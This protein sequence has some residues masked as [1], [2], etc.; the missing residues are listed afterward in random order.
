MFGGQ[1]QAADLYP[2]Y[3]ADVGP[4]TL[5]EFAGEGLNSGKSSKDLRPFRLASPRSDLFCHHTYINLRNLLAIHL[6]Q[7][8][9]GQ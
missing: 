9:I 7:Q 6:V 1:D 3:G 8:H 5:M 4:L 2:A